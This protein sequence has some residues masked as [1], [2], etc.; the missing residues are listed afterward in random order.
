MSH[1]EIPNGSF[2]EDVD[3]DGIPDRWSVFF[4]P[5]G[6]GGYDTGE[7]VH[8][9]KSYKLIHPGGKG[10]GGGYL[11]SDY[12]RADPLFLKPVR[13]ACKASA[14][15]IKVACVVLH[16]D[17]GK[18][19]LGAK[20]VYASTANPTAWGLVV[21]TNLPWSF[22]GTEYVKVRLVGGKDD[23]DVA[24]TVWF[25]AVGEEGSP[26][27]VP[28]AETVD[29]APVSTHS[30]GYVDVG[31]P[32]DITLPSGGKFSWLVVGMEL[33]GLSW[34]NE[35]G[36]GSCRPKGRFRIGSR[37]SSEATGPGTAVWGGPYYPSLNIDG[38]SGSRRVHFQLREEPDAGEKVFL[39]SPAAARKYFRS[40]ARVVDAGEGTVADSGRE[41]PVPP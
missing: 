4:Y 40:N 22:P 24:G 8:G 10:N 25:G 36:E 1:M 38:I 5:G 41:A 32:W 15:G 9:R 18:G 23:T 21:V 13:F 7:R 19:F 14:A 33:K 35:M 12:V 16:Y 6:S 17:G 2:E 28:V 31:T 39:R 34:S 11:E 27:S 20:E 29:Q 37:F 26:A 30:G 3:S